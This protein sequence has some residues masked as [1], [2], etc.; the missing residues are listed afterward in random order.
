V[1]MTLPLL[2]AFF[3]ELKREAYGAAASEEILT[4]RNVPPVYDYASYRV[5]EDLA[6]ETR[7]STQQSNQFFASNSVQS[8]VKDDSSQHDIES[9]NQRLR[10]MLESEDPSSVDEM[11]ESP[12]SPGRDDGLQ[13][14][15]QM[16]RF[17]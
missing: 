2:T 15:L 8:S 14:E 9:E 11:E 7:L 13:V 17:K 5:S 16:D 10:G 12:G 3:K 1:V 6:L 4:Q